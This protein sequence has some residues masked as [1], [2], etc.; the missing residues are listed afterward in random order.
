MAAFRA[1]AGSLHRPPSGILLPSHPSR[2][3]LEAEEREVTVLVSAPEAASEEEVKLED[4][5]R[6][7]RPCIWIN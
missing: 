4:C 1:R 7:F 2:L 6:L 5:R 3:R